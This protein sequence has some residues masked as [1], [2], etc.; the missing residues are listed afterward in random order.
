M[1]INGLVISNWIAK[2]G[3]WPLIVL[4]VPNLMF[5]RYGQSAGKK[6]MSSLL[7]AIAVFLITTMAAFIAER[8]VELGLSDKYLF[9]GIAAVAVLLYVF[10]ERVFPYR[11]SCVKCD[12][13][14]E[15]K[16]IYFMDD[17]LCTD[18]HSKKVA[19]EETAEETVAESADERIS[20]KT[21][22]DETGG[23]ETSRIESEDGDK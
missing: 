3:I 1:D 16:T 9:V 17:N 22:S 6:R 15:F 23:D 5:R 20:E 4:L 21:E 10:R 7:Q 18:C 11:L 14:L 2:L 13:R 19:R 12:A 8:G